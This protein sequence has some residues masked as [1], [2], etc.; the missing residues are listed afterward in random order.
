M[1]SP[2]ISHSFTIDD[3]HRRQQ[4][5]VTVVGVQSTDGK[6]YPA[7]QPVAKV[8]G[9]ASAK[10]LARF[11][12]QL[13]NVD[14]RGFVVSFTATMQLPGAVDRALGTFDL[15]SLEMRPETAPV[16]QERGESI[17]LDGLGLNLGGR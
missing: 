10:E 16:I 11:L 1:T 12:G 5:A 4:G 9:L 6:V 8:L 7:A 15:L 13:A 3:I 14:G 17:S 2:A